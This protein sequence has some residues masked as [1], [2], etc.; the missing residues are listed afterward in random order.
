MGSCYSNQGG[1]NGQNAQYGGQSGFNNPFGP[2]LGI[3][4]G[5]CCSSKFFVYKTNTTFFH[6]FNSTE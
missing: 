1:I 4:V 5:V 6:Q 3:A 2:A